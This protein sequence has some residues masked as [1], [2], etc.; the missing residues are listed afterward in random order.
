[1]NRTSAY[2]V[3]I[4]S[5][6]TATML[7]AQTAE[8]TTQPSTQPATQPT[9]QPTTQQSAVDPAELQRRREAAI[10]RAQQQ[11]AEQEQRKREIEERKRR[12]REEALAWWD[13]HGPDVKA[14]EAQIADL[15]Q[16]L[17]QAELEVKDLKI[18][19]DRELDRLNDQYK[20]EFAK[21]EEANDMKAAAAAKT[22]LIE[23]RR[24]TNF[25][26]DRLIEE[27][28]RR[29]DAILAQLRDAERAR[30]EFLAKAPK[31]P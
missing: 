23:R 14:I 13:A 27:A 26:Y 6:C 16:Q 10:A 21:A 18:D 25:R 22:R 28:R 20:K 4:I 9:T 24:E 17:R 11:K 30:S 31:R 5:M 2:C 15:R 8:P 1:M 3:L 7:V 29:T 12:E 19:R